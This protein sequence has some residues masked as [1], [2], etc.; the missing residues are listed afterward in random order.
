[1]FNIHS[2]SN[3]LDFSTT[4]TLNS[5]AHFITAMFK[6]APL[7][8]IFAAGAMGEAAWTGD[9]EAEWTWTGFSKPINNTEIVKPPESFPRPPVRFFCPE[10]KVAQCVS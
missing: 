6:L 1:L 8:G 2:T 3:S 4:Q 9:A 10:D 7:L 5:V